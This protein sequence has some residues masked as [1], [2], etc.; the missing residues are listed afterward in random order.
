MH[1]TSKHKVPT[2]TDYTTLGEKLLGYPIQIDKSSVQL[3][4]VIAVGAFGV[5]FLATEYRQG[6]RTERSYAVKC[7]LRNHYNPYADKFVRQE[8]TNHSA[9]RHPNVVTVFRIAEHVDVVFI[10]M[11]Y[12]PNGDLFKAIIDRQEFVAQDDKVRVAWLQIAE[13]VRACHAQGIYHRDIKPENILIRSTVNPA[14]HLVLAD[15]GLSTKEEWSFE[16]GV[17]SSF[18]MSPGMSRS[19]LGPGFRF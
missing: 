2:K 8:T 14:L 3:K 7:L 12:C 6:K 4:H 15:F 13:G 9:V 1:Y 10:I 18:Y 16:F 11:E 17:G 19:H 5:I